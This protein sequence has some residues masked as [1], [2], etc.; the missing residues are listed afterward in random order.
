M[1]GFYG[2]SVRAA[3]PTALVTNAGASVIHLVPEQEKK[4]AFQFLNTGTATWRS[5]GASPIRFTHPGYPK[6]YRH[7]FQ[8]LQ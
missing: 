8:S 1:T 4:L 3:Q 5:S 6:K 2:S 7:G